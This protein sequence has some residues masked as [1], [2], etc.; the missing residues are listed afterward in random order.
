MDKAIEDG[1]P[2]EECYILEVHRAF[3][4]LV[5]RART[6]AVLEKVGIFALFEVERRVTGEESNRPFNANIHR[7]TIRRYRHF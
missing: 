3:W 2:A 6:N 5:W 4:R 7:N 1:R